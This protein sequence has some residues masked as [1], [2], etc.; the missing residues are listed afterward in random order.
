MLPEA[1][2][3]RRARERAIARRCIKGTQP[4]DLIRLLQPQLTGRRRKDGVELRT[5]QPI[6]PVPR[7]VHAPALDQRLAIVPSGAALVRSVRRREEQQLAGVAAWSVIGNRKGLDDVVEVVRDAKNSHAVQDER[8][9]A[10]LA[11]R[12]MRCLQVQVRASQLLLVRVGRSRQCSGRQDVE[13]AWV[14]LAER[15]L[16]R[17]QDHGRLDGTLDV[18][19]RCVAQQRAPP[20][21]ARCWRGL[22]ASAS[23]VEGVAVRV[24]EAVWEWFGGR[25]A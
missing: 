6:E 17:V 12:S 5:R 4:P 7:V 1:E 15:D 16:C 3:L 13:P 10:Q 20:Q 25:N 21:R 24:S 22:G 14:V 11:R 2:R 9:L 19:A 8:R 18:A 23:T